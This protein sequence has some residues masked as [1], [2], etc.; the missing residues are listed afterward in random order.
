[1]SDLRK[2]SGAE[3]RRQARSGA[4]KGPTPGLAMGYVQ[5]NLVVVPR[6][7]AFDFLLFCHRNPQPCPLLDVTDPGSPEPRQVA[8][9][10]DVR[11]DIPRYCAYRYGELVEESDD[12]FSWWRDDLV[13]FLLGCSFTFENALVEA[14][15]PV[16]HI[17]QGRNVPMYR[18]NIACR[19]AGQF[20]GRLVVSMR[21]L[22]PAQAEVAARI[23]RRFPKAHGAPVHQG[24]PAAIGIHD[25]DRPDFGD[26]VEIRH[27]EVPV[28]WACGVTPQAVAMEARPSL[29]LTH[30]PGHMFVT[31]L[32][33]TELLE[34]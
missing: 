16:R 14:G 2:A 7:L 23:C 11:S 10:A 6:D 15:L 3:V 1:V 8:P 9:G 31:D 20:H 24:D 13:A 12:L 32:R 17:E 26:P 4:L 27:G 22:T 21:P 18:T 5:A 29:L 28:F 34:R 19:P 25:I 33:D 30:K